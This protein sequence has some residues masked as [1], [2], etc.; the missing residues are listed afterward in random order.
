MFFLLRYTTQCFRIRTERKKPKRTNNSVATKRL[1][2]ICTFVNCFKIDK[3]HFSHFYRLSV[4]THFNAI[5]YKWLIA[6]NRK[7]GKWIE[8][9]SWPEK[10]WTHLTTQNWLS[11]F[12]LVIQFFFSSRY[13]HWLSNIFIHKYLNQHICRSIVRFL[14]APKLNMVFVYVVGI[15]YAIGYW[16][17]FII[18]WSWTS[19]FKKAFFTIKI[20]RIWCTVVFISSFYIQS[21]WEFN[22]LLIFAKYSSGKLYNVINSSLEKLSIQKWNRHFLPI[23]WNYIASLLA[24][25]Q[26][27]NNGHVMQ[28]Y[29]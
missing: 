14:T 20:Q 2:Y 29:S 16:C 10:N 19:Q 25:V 22:F 12:K 26:I 8:L 3:K 6:I 5:V 21:L 1:C 9:F 7:Y 15:K 27:N 4:W 28:I 17:V 24:P 11:L 18:N 23:W 13:I